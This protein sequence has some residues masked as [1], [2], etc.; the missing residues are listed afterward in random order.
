MNKPI[1]TYDV[2][3]YENMFCFCGKFMGDD[4][5]YVFE[6][7]EFKNELPQ[8]VQFLNWLMTIRPDQPLCKSI[9]GILMNAFKG[10]DFDY[11]FVHEL[12]GN[13]H[14]FTYQ[15]AKHLQRELFAAQDFNGNN[16][17]Q[18]WL[19]DRYIDQ[20]DLFKLHHFD[21]RAKTTNLKNIQFV[22]RSKT[23]A[24]LPY[25]PDQPL[26]Y[27]QAREVIQYCCH[28]VYRLEDF[29]IESWPQVQLRLDFLDEKILYGDV[30][31]Y[32]DTKIGKEYLAQQLGK[33][34]THEGKN[35]KQTFRSSVR[36]E[37]ILLP[38]LSFE[39]PVCQSVLDW[40]KTVTVYPGNK[41]DKDDKKKLQKTIK[42]NGVEY[43]FGL[44][45]AHGSVEKKYFKSDDEWV[46]VDVDVTSY[47]PST[48]IVHGW[49]PEH[50]GHPFV[51]YYKDLKAKRIQ[52]PKESAMN[53]VLKLALNGV[54][55]D[56][57][58]IHSIYYDPKFL[59][60]ITINCQMLIL[61][62]VEQFCLSVPSLQ[63]IQANTDGVTAKFPRRYLP[64]FEM[65]MQLWQK[66]TGLQ[67]E[68]VFYE[69]MWVR[70]VN[71]YLA[72]SDKGKVKRK[73]AYWYPEKKEEL[74]GNW[75]KDLSALVIQK[76]AEKVM[77][78]GYSPEFAVSMFTDPFDYMLRYKTTGESRVYIGDRKMLKTT[79]YYV[80]TAGEKMSK[81]TPAKASGYKRKPGISDS[82]FN[83][84]L[85]EVGTA[86]DARI[87]TGNK[88]VYAE[89]NSSIESGWLVKECNDASNFNA[90]DI[91]YNYYIEKVKDLIIR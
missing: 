63:I 19:S 20:L 30:L 8:L 7:S 43:V 67:L 44:G 9:K 58:N 64:W 13:P 4:R 6:I 26:T 47:Y 35:K 70:D 73:G 28:D 16:R 77:I 31:N 53:K 86:W 36:F 41:K 56:S 88:S 78:E 57:N 71:N 85:A 11:N 80:S 2:E 84:V 66:E 32:N 54:F 91:D 5:M 1:F 15:K 79:R 46:I 89:S 83:E 42:F 3:T 60:S 62:L 50:L 72:I 25:D 17:K 51:Q 39:T 34:V 69:R 74:E 68:Q 81:L 87:H 33:A 10:L 61:K 40:Y 90:R 48:A 55:G 21:N 24:D 23:V 22:M 12:I 75:H 14:Q 76:A 18:I 29:T 82:Y 59:Y 27:E 45:G 52:Y 65:V 38:S 37:E 49:C